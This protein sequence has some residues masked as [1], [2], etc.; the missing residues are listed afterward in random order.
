MEK[1][2]QSKGATAQKKPKGTKFCCGV[3]YPHPQCIDCPMRQWDIK[4]AKVFATDIV[5]STEKSIFYG[6]KPSRPGERLLNLAR[7]FLGRFRRK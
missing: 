1:T 6:N 7:A 2:I 3:P 4:D 5:Q